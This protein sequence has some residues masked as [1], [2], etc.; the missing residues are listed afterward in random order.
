MNMTDIDLIPVDYRNWLDQQSVVRRYLVGLMLVNLLVVT[1]GLTLG[2]SAKQ[3]QA[4]VTELKTASAITQQQ[5]AQLEQ[6]RSQEEE[7]ERR[8]SLLRGLRAGAAI[9]EIFSLID[10]SL[11]A[12]DLWFLD[13]SFRRA[14]VVVDGQP[15]GVETGYFVIVADDDDPFAA[16]DLEVETHMNIHGQARDH[17]ALSRFVRALFE[18]RDIKDVNVQRTSQTDYANGRVVEFDLTIVLHSALRES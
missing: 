3:A 1:A 14:G 15:R 5:Q 6:L 18:Q 8:W 13:W 4:R 12:G 11:N 16:A 7:Y 9:D 17:Q 10:R 2:Y